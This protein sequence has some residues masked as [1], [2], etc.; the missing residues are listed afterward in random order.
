LSTLLL[1][2]LN[3]QKSRCTLQTKT[4]LNFNND[5]L[6]N[7]RFFTLVHKWSALSNIL[8]ITSAKLTQWK[9]QA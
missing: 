5:A 4:V 2:N 7:K 8:T 3:D 9:I 6:T 1:P